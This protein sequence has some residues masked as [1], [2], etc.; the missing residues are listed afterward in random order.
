MLRLHLVGDSNVD[1]YLSIAKTA[2]EDPAIQET[3]FV[4]ATNLV[5][6]KEAL[7]PSSP[8]ES[9]PNVILACLTNPITNH[10]FD[11]Y[12]TLV[13][14]CNQTFAQI[15]AWI[16]EGRVAT[17]GT[18]RQVYFCFMLYVGCLNFTELTRT[19]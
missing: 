8:S 7:V 17:P 18:M 12:K 13:T 2:K 16:Q 14:H 1:R 4:R 19:V 10:P 11:E 3:S 9:H 15:L 5:Q 6:V